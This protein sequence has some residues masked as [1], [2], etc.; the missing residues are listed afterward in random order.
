VL[1]ADTG[2]DLPDFRA[3]ERTFQLLSQVAGRAGRGERPGRV[4]I[5]TY[6]P[7]AIAVT[8]AAAH[9]Y[10]AFYAAEIEARGDV[11]EVGYPPSGR[12]IAVRI[13]GADAAAVIATAGRLGSTAL[14]VA[15]EVRQGTGETVVVRGP[16]AAPLERLRGRTRWVI[17]L[18]AQQRHALRKVARALVGIEPDRGVRVGLDVDPVS[19]L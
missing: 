19:A 9:D 2:L 7:T 17:W 15:A 3:S 18:R 14:R 11:G 10:Q 4:L 13:D 16:V 12:Q 1:C 6:R 8:A 5:Q